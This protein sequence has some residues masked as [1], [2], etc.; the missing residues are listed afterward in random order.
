MMHFRVFFLLTCFLGPLFSGETVEA[1]WSRLGS[2]DDKVNQQVLRQLLEH[3][4]LPKELRSDTKRLYEHVKLWNN[5]K[6]TTL[7]PNRCRQSLKI[8]PGYRLYPLAQYYYAR[9][10]L[11]YA[12]QYGKIRHF[13]DR[14]AK[15]TADAL[16][17]FRIAE[18]AYPDNEIIAMYLDRKRLPWPVV[19]EEDPQAPDWANHQ[20]KILEGLSDVIIWWIEER[21]QKNGAFTSGRGDDVEMWRWWAP[22]LVGFEGPK[23]IQG[24][25]RLSSWVIKS[26]KG[27][28]YTGRS[29]DVEH[30]S[31]DST[32]SIVPMMYA[33]PGNEVWVK[34]AR[35]IGDLYREKWTGVN[36]REFLQFKNLNF[37]YKG[38]TGGANE[39]CDTLWH[40]RAILPTLLL[41]QQGDRR[42]D[43]QFLP[44][45]DTWVD[46]T[47][48]E[49]RGKPAGVMP[50]AIHWP[51][52]RIGGPGPRWWIPEI[53]PEKL[54]HWPFHLGPMLQQLL[55]AWHMSGDETYLAPMHSM[56]ALY[57]EHLANPVENPEPG[58]RAWCASKLK[59]VVDIVAKYRM[60]TGDTQYDD[61]LKGKG[62]NAYLKFRI[63]G[64]RKGLTDA[65]A[66]DAAALS[67]NFPMYT[68][69]ARWCDRVLNRPG[70]WVENSPLETDMPTLRNRWN[71]T[72]LY[73]SVTGDI[74]GIETFPL[75]AVRWNTPAREIAALVTEADTDSFTA[76]LYHFGK[77]PREM[78]A[79]FWLLKPGTY[80]VSLKTD[81]GREKQMSVVIVKPGDGLPF[82]IPPRIHLT[83]TVTAQKE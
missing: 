46:A 58:S 47:A 6:D 10:Y 64:N 2:A 26:L 60:L 17:A 36:E 33:D 79:E 80:K 3:P 56:A 63:S 27:Q 14:R 69:E 21:Q 51:S 57:R 66:N 34:H 28:S 70:F 72:E 52:G 77:T 30:T 54:Y 48:R 55:L 67:Q 31:E 49:E 44:W 12:L 22:V 11:G 45:F 73:T 81:E 7:G 16:E 13:E 24:Q 15:A 32:D 42:Y 35:V 75:R 20:R 61:L 41:W 74:G 23:V 37:T 76:E 78:G 19:Y 68:Q 29:D 4:D 53:Y 62:G 71:M 1:L 5:P 39:A 18:Q 8:K 9:G 82:T 40:F 65:L 83:L 59:T 38:I 50:S 43:E 25:S